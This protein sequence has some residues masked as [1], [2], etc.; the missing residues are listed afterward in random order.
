MVPRSGTARAEASKFSPRF[1]AA[2]STKR[3]VWLSL[4]AQRHLGKPLILADGDDPIF[5]ML[6][7]IPRMS[8]TIQQEASFASLDKGAIH[9][10]GWEGFYPKQTSIRNIP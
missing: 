6:F 7:V 10:I 3:H 2:A 5:A 9:A 1:S 4:M 8:L